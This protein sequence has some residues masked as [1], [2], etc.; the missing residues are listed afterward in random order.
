MK[1]FSKSLTATDCL[2]RL[3]IP[4]RVLTSL[5][6][7]H[8]GHAVEL[9]VRYE[10]MEWSL[11]C[12]IRKKGYKKPVLSKGWRKFVLANNLNVGDELTLHKEEDESGLLHYRVEVKRATRPS[13]ALSQSPPAPEHDLDESHETTS[14]RSCRNVE[15][16]RVPVVN[17]AYQTSAGITSCSRLYQFGFTMDDIASV[18]GTDGAT[19]ETNNSLFKE[20]TK[21][22]EYFNFGLTVGG[23]VVHVHDQA[24]SSTSFCKTDQRLG[25]DLDMILG[26]SIEA[27]GVVNLDLTLEPPILFDGE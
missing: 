14:A 7:F 8:G 16:K 21:V 18:R 12:T 13:R 10:T 6:V 2:K 22:R 19:D 17:G 4:K 27:R 26:Q 20:E 3:S 15:E 11:V 24:T 9:Q 5:P 1:L 25:F 23:A